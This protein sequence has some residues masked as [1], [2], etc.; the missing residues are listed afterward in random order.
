[1]NVMIS[2]SFFFENAFSKLLGDF[3]GKM[4]G[5]GIGLPIS[6]TFLALYGGSIQLST[7]PGTE[8]TA[9]IVW[10]RLGDFVL[11]IK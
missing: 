9:K 2:L 1:M 5:L 3:G 6:K 8:T 4:T 7:I 11:E 10:P